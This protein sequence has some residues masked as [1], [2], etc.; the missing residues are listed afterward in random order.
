MPKY[1]VRY[2]RTTEYEAEVEA[3]DP[4]GAE[5]KA[6]Y[7]IPATGTSESLHVSPV[8]IQADESEDA[9]S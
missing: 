6:R 4:I 3:D 7:E 5:T 2:R 9:S 8:H 1:Y